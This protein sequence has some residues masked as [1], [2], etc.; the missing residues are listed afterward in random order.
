MYR[1]PGLSS[2]RLSCSLSL[3][4]SIRLRD[5]NHNTRNAYVNQNTRPQTGGSHI[6][7][8]IRVM[9]HTIKHNSFHEIYH[10][11]LFTLR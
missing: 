9:E 3:P 5:S 6:I 7:K 11:L 1:S 4:S 8:D 10:V 2:R